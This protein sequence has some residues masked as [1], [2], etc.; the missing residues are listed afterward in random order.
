MAPPTYTEEF[1]NP[2]IEEAFPITPKWDG[3]TAI[4][5]VLTA[6]MAV[7]EIASIIKEMTTLFPETPHKINRETA[8][9]RKN[10]PAVRISFLNRRMLAIDAKNTPDRLKIGI[11]MVL[12]MAII[13]SNW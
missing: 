2:D 12:T 6:I 10:A 13:F 1:N 3:K 7:V 9:T 8:H 4:S 11:T 5:I